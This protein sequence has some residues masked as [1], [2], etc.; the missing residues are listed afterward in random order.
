MA[1]ENRGVSLQKFCSK[2]DLYRAT[3][4]RWVYLYRKYGL[5]GL[6]PSSEWKIYS[7]EIKM[8]AT[9]DYSSAKY[10]QS[11]IIHK[12]EISHCTVLIKWI[13]K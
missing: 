3:I 7:I 11:E 12:Y 13:K 10:S 9:L 8:V 2:Y 6:K 4:N 5:G 1:Y